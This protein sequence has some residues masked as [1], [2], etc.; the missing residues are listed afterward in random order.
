MKK[1]PVNSEPQEIKTMVLNERDVLCALVS[2]MGSA[3]EQ[4]DR[5]LNR[6][7]NK[8]AR[9][10]ARKIASETQAASVP[11]KMMLLAMHVAGS[12]EGTMSWPAEI[13]LKK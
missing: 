5:E 7:R 8:P 10:R 13:D 3:L 11:Y 6:H 12:P 1:P 4:I 9:A 2:L